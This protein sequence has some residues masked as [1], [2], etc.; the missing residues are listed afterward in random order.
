MPAR[1]HSDRAKGRQ[2]DVASLAQPARGGSCG[3]GR[4]GALS[5]PAPR[6]TVIRAAGACP[7]GSASPVTAARSAFRVLTRTRSGYAGASLHDVQLQVTGTG[8]LAW[9]WTFSSADEAQRFKAS[10]EDDL[11]ELDVVGFSR[12]HGV[13]TPTG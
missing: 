5:G 3:G 10:L 12:K 6:G 13:P 2:W 1:S 11:A 9:A 4:R 7:R 8:E